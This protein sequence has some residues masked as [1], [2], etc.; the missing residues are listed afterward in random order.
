MLR[1]LIVFCVVTVGWV[2][3]KLPDFAQVRDLAVTMWKNRHLPF[4][5]GGPLQIFA[6]SLPVVAYHLLYKMRAT[7]P[8]PL[9]HLFGMQT[10]GVLLGA[11]LAMIVLQAGSPVPFIYFQF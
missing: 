1:W 6:Y 11:L 4:A 9:S 10:E 2:L 7:S 3:F 5:P 8:R